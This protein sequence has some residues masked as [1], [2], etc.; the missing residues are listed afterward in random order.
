MILHFT[1]AEYGCTFDFTYDILKVRHSYSAELRP[2]QKEGEAEGSGRGFMLSPCD[3]IPTGN[4]M[5]AALKA[6]TPIFAQEKGNKRH[7]R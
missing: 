6:V 5:F 3:I 7:K 4:E 1:D 2:S